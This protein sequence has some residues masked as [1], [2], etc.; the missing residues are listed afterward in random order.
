MTTNLKVRYDGKNLIPLEPV[1]LPV[2]SEWQIDV[3][4]YGVPASESARR[5]LEAIWSLPKLDE[6]SMDKFDQ[7]LFDARVYGKIG[8]VFDD[9]IEEDSE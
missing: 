6:A 3:R 8:G 1:D 4:E 2:D 5:L 7:A 9:L